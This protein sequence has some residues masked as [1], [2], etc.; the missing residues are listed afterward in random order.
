MKKLISLMLCICMLLSALSVAAREDYIELNSL[1]YDEYMRGETILV[2]GDTNVYV[3]LGLYYPESYGSTAKYIMTYSPQEL[4]DGIEIETG[5]DEKL[6]PDG[7]WTI[8]VQSGDMSESLEF[9]L[10]ETVD[11]TE[12]E[13][14]PEKPDRKPNTG[15]DAPKVVSIVPDKTKVT[16]EVDKS[17]TINITTL[18]TSLTVEVDDT[19]IVASSISGKKLTITGLKTGSSVIWVKGSNNFATINVTVVPKTEV[20]EKPDTNKDTETTPT[21]P[22]D[23]QVKPEDNKKPLPFTDVENHWAKSSIE[24]L[25]NLGIIAGMDEDT[26]APDDNVTRAQFVTMLQKAFDLKFKESSS[27]F[28]D[29]KSTDWYF[30]SV[31][32]AY[33]NGIAAGYGGMFNP[34]SLVTRQDMAVFAFR[35]AIHA[36][37]VF[38]LTDI[39]TFTDHNS[40]SDYAVE[41]VYSM[42]SASV[43]NG[44]TDKTFE[45]MGNATRAQAAHII[46]KLLDL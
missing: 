2:S 14:E 22:K 35:A 46:A 20:E 7:L 42:R 8:V 28:A 12:E 18:A 29:V 19:D 13:E 9:T 11:R 37:K 30:A 16:L 26:F 27:P 5:T 39:T 10:S 45:P 33:E 38:M 34:N 23:P 24:K 44:M 4:R 41:A 1:R 40:I 43:I 17:E 25:Y 15:S 3:T 21:K 6:W 32:A 36:D 31:M